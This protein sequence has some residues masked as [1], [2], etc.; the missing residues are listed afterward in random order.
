MAN[1]DYEY[2][3]DSDYDAGYDDEPLEP[4]RGTMILILGILSLAV[5]G[6]IGPFAWAMGRTDL[7]KMKIGVMDDRGYNETQI[8]YILGIVATII[9]GIGLVLSLLWF[10][11]VFGFM[12]VAAGAKGG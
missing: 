5:C 4:H 3:A 10:V 8:G 2:D 1:R 9:V 6:L 7:R 12:A 11:V